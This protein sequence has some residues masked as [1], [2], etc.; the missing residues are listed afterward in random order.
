MLKKDKKNTHQKPDI[1]MSKKNK[2]PIN[3]IIIDK[4]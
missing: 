1:I 3:L 2:N 4:L